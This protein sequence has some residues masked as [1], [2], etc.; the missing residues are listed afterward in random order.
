MEKLIRTR[1]IGIIRLP[2]ELLL[3]FLQYPNGV[4]KAVSTP[5]D[6]A[7]CIDIV[8]EHPEMPELQT[9]FHI[10]VITPS[11]HTYTD[12]LGHKVE[13]RESSKP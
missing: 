11:F 8:L 7:D 4:I 3:K 13:V 6:I 9:G 1:N 10:P 2:Q 12:C 5:I